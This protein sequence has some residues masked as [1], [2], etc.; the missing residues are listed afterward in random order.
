MWNWCKNIALIRTNRM[1]IRLGGSP[2]LGELPI[3]SW[4][5]WRKLPQR[6]RYTVLLVVGKWLWKPSFPELYSAT[7][8]QPL[9]QAHT[10]RDKGD[11]RHLIRRSEY[12]HSSPEDPGRHRPPRR[13]PSSMFTTST[14][15]A[16]PS[17]DY[18]NAS[19]S[20]TL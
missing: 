15:E 1:H 14:Q 5:L 2:R 6:L 11:S 19:R 3:V 9:L 17:G 10:H 13:G 12:D 7:P 16:P 18:D 4:R 8:I 20:N